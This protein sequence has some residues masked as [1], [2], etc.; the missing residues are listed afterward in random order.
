M[1]QR[2]PI[3]AQ[4]YLRKKGQKP[5]KLAPAPAGCSSTR[6]IRSW[7]R[8]SGDGIKIL[9][10]SFLS[11]PYNYLWPRLLASYWRIKP[12][13]NIACLECSLLCVSIIY[14]SFLRMRC[15]SHIPTFLLENIIVEPLVLR[16][17]RW[18]STTIREDG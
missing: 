11:N 3:A 12:F 18:F 17:Q 4:V 14:S 15:L 2:D 16:A 6:V 10:Y 1:P 13:L 5:T 9:R 8:V 7:G